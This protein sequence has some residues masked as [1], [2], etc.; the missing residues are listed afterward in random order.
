VCILTACAKEIAWSPKPQKQEPT[1]NFA[2]ATK[3]FATTNG[4][5]TRARVSRTR[6]WPVQRAPTHSCVWRGPLRC[7]PPGPGRSR[8]RCP[9]SLPMRTRRQHLHACVCVRVC[10]C[11]CVRVCVCACARVRVCACARVSVCACVR[12]GAC[13]RGGGGRRVRGEACMRPHPGRRRSNCA[14]CTAHVRRPLPPVGHHLQ[15]YTQA[16]RA[17]HTHHKAPAHST[18]CAALP[19]A[20][21]LRPCETYELRRK[22][23][24]GCPHIYRR[25]RAA[26]HVHVTMTPLLAAVVPPL[27]FFTL[28]GSSCR[29]LSCTGV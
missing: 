20:E 4:I 28:E 13:G 25:Y 9:C 14:V 16:S 10:M 18:L 17:T 26:V 7:R 11:A 19:C 24:G 8:A 23:G 6:Y 21:T 29:R 5:A 1:I 22:C 15:S 2:G 27:M 12:V 3:G